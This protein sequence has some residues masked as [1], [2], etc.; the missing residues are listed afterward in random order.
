MSVE[1]TL[2]EIDEVRNINTQDHSKVAVIKTT[3]SMINRRADATIRDEIV[4]RVFRVTTEP[5][6]R[7]FVTYQF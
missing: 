1:S 2:F 3:I 7:S 4:T 5:E 6:R